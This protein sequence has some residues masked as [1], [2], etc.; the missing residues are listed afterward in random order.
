MKKAIALVL[1]FILIT[2]SSISLAEEEFYSGLYRVGKDIKV[3]SYNIRL[4][5]IGEYPT[6]GWMEV[7]DSEEDYS[8]GNSSLFKKFGPEGVHISAVEGMVF[9]I[10]LIGDGKLT[11]VTDKPSWMP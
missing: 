4:E 1:S 10:G 11:I 2:F 9:T 5:R 8:V 3:G 6:C 7:F